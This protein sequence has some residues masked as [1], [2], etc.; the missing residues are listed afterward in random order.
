MNHVGK[1]PKCEATVST[2]T[3][4]VVEIREHGQSI[5]SGG[6]YLCP[7]CNAV[8]GVGLH[9]ESMVSDIVQRVKG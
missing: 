8:L 7:K 5:A 6:L 3:F 4:E 9:P 1:C 2:V